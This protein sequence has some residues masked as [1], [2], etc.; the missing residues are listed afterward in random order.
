MALASFSAV[1]ANRKKKGTDWRRKMVCD[2][3]GR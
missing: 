3:A 1:A 2:L